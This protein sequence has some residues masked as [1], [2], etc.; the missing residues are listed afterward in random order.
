MDIPNKI[1]KLNFNLRVLRSIDVVQRIEREDKKTFN[2]LKTFFK[3]HTN[4]N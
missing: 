2:F 4:M 1:L 3:D